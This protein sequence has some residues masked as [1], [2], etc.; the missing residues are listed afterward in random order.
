MRTIALVSVLWLAMV[1]SSYAQ[2]INS[3]GSSGAPVSVSTA[4][5]VLAYQSGRKSWCIEPESVAVRC[6]PSNSSAAPATTPTSTVGFYFPA[7]TI[8][9]HNSV[10]IMAQGDPAQYVRLD[11][12]STGSATKCDT[13][14]Q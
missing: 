4:T 1:G 2:V 10:P 6:E 12:A 8:T 7:G 5:T 11:C 3:Q 9:C 14:E 13:W